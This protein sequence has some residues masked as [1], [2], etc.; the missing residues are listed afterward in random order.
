MFETLVGRS[1][2]AYFVIK[3]EFGVYCF[4]LG[5]APKCFSSACANI[6]RVHIKCNQHIQESQIVRCDF[7]H[8]VP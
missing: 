1:P 6:F 8:E 2:Q 4:V 3:L 7:I 5:E